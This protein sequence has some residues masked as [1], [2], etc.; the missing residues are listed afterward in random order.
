VAED[1]HPVVRL[2]RGADLVDGFGGRE[3]RGIEAE[4]LVGPIEVVVDRLRHADDFDPLAGVPV[5]HGHRAIPADRDQGIESEPLEVPDD[6]LRLVEVNIVAPLRS[7]CRFSS[8][9]S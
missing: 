8:I 1:H 9:W 2:R 7:G 5:R 4:R 6:L 3:D